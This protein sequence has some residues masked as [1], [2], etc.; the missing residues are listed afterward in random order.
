M[1]FHFLKC[2]NWIYCTKKP[3]IFHEILLKLTAIF[4][5]FF[6]PLFAEKPA[7]FM[8]LSPTAGK[9]NVFAVFYNFLTT[10]TDIFRSFPL[11]FII[12]K[13]DFL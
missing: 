12:F 6:A 7:I 5:N 11:Y 10:K 4:L 1:H 2:I 3:P 8:E 9:I 13:N